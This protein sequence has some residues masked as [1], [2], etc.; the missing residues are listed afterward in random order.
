MNKKKKKPVMTG[1]SHYDNTHI[2]GSFYLYDFAH[3]IDTK[4]DTYGYS[5][6]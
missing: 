2:H 6:V 4:I 5:C 3:F 1:D